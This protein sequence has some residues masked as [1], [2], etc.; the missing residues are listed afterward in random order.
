MVSFM[1][2]NKEKMR[3]ISSE[4]KKSYGRLGTLKSHMFMHSEE[5]THT[6]VECQ[7]LFDQAGNR[8]AHMPTHCGVVQTER[9]HLVEHEL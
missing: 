1:L 6:C 4:Y 9:N 5:K 8:N 3:H 7:R 2:T